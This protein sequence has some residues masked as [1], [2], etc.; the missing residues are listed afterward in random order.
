M[1]GTKRWRDE[2]DEEACCAVVPSMDP[3]ASTRP[4]HRS[5]DVDVVPA[6][7]VHDVLQAHT[8]LAPVKGVAPLPARARKGSLYLLHRHASVNEGLAVLGDSWRLRLAALGVIVRTLV[9]AHR[10]GVVHGDMHIK[11]IVVHKGTPSPRVCMG[12]WRGIGSAATDAAALVRIVQ[13]SLSQVPGVPV[14]VLVAC[15]GLTSVAAACGMEG[16]AQSPLFDQAFGRG[17]TLT[18]PSARPRRTFSSVSHKP[19]KA[20]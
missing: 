19:L 6:S 5:D 3:T 16:V 11:H 9:H 4:T 1:P 15:A 20:Q 12:G 13:T 7:V 2:E 8:A 10:I 17:T 18:V 14:G